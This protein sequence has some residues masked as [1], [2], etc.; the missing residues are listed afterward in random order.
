MARRHYPHGVAG[1]FT[2]LLALVFLSCSDLPT[3]PTPS[4]MGPVGKPLFACTPLGTEVGALP[5]TMGEPTT[6]TSTDECLEI[7]DVRT[8]FSYAEPVVDDSPPAWT[9]QG[10]TVAFDAVAASA[11]ELCPDMI[12]R[13]LPFQKDINGERVTFFT[14]GGAIKIRDVGWA[15]DGSP[16][17]LYDLQDE[18]H[19]SRRGNYEAW[20]GTLMVNCKRVT[21]L[22][23]A[24]IRFQMRLFATF[25]YQGDIIRSSIEGSGG[26]WSYANM[27][28]GYRNGISDGW[29]AALDLYLSSGSCTPSWDIWIDGVQKCRNGQPVNTV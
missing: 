25:D 12:E 13:R 1:T 5:L 3:A 4:V 6:S 27:E 28:T 2:S 9:W 18:Y 7:V 29:Q 19:K 23:I 20:G 21:L 8:E 14:T 26:G 11:A 17:A 10:E 15:R 22:T 24:G 16:V